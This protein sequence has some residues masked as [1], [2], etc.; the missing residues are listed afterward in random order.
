M[1]DRFT[2]QP[3]WG[4]CESFRGALQE[5]GKG[6]EGGEPWDTE[7]TPDSGTACDTQGRPDSWLS[8]PAGPSASCDVVING[9]RCPEMLIHIAVLQTSHS[10]TFRSTSR[11]DTPGSSGYWFPGVWAQI[12]GNR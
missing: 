3:Q 9:K 12:G 1:A 4:G 10:F 5:Q 11:L 7:D 2:V 6:Q 8:S